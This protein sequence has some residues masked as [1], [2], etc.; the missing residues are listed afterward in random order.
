MSTREFNSAAPIGS[1]ADYDKV[2]EYVAERSRALAKTVLGRDLRLDTLTVFTQTPDEYGVV[3]KLLRSYG[4]ESPFS[5]G[6]TLYIE[7][8]KNVLDQQINLLGVRQPDA[9]RPQRGYGDYPVSDYGALRDNN[10][11]NP[12][13]REIVSGNG[14]TLLELRHPDF[15]VLGYVVD[16]AAHAG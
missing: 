7:V 8:R 3:S 14:H 4:P 15:D 1:E 16:E 9:T 11:A 13:V 6:P 12:H 10:A 5:H 2:L